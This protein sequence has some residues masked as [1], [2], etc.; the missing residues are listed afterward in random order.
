MKQIFF[1]PILL[2]KKRSVSYVFQD[3][4]IR[5]RFIPYHLGKAF[6]VGEKKDKE[7]LLLTIVD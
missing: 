2:L 1:F 7:K 5:K 6:T 3:R 4:K